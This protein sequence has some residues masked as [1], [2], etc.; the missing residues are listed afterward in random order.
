MI[1]DEICTS[2]KTLL[3][4]ANTVTILTHI[5]PDADTI[6]TGLGVYAILRKML[7]VPVEIVN[8]SKDLP[9]YLDFLPAYTK[10]KKRI[11]FETGLVITCDGGS[12]E[13]FGVDLSGREI[14]NIDHHHSN[15]MFGT[16]NVVIAE[17]ASA[18]Q[19]AY[20][21]FERF[22]TITPESARCFYTA[23]LSDTLYFTT[24]SVNAEVFEV[25]RELISCGADPSEA[26]RNLTQR[27]SLASLRILERALHSL[28]LYMEG[29]VAVMY[30]SKSD[31]MA[32]GATMPDM[33]GIVDHARSLAVVR[34]AVLMIELDD[35]GIKISFRGKQCDVSRLA[36][37]FGG[38]GHKEAAGVTLKEAQI[39]EIID[40]ILENIST[41][42]LIH[43]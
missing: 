42:G 43:G 24:S 10:I 31:R 33:D 5:N 29:C 6:G 23:L 4:R 21:L 2:V 20:R 17:Y 18:S 22:A 35:G 9:R 16:V 41:L 7:D 36:S 28:S 13:R 25:A 32:T 3:A 11:D 27:R 26:A 12:L 14:I 30:I 1:S 40:T 39:Q 34:I 37:V 15:D 38:G 19:V 8:V